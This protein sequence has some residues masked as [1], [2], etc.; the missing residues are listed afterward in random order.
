MDD[1]KQ[2]ALDLIINMTTYNDYLP[3]GAP[4]STILS[5]IAH[6]V[7]F[8]EI[9]EEMKKLT[10]GYD[11]M[12]FQGFANIIDEN[13]RLKSTAQ[14]CL[15]WALQQGILPLPKSITPSRIVENT[16]IFDF[17]IS[18]DDMAAINALPNFGGSGL[19]PDKVDF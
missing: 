5:F 4:T 19:H 18:P 8:D 3:T 9:A 2:K 17:T 15:R 13:K 10:P 1:D 16:N 14:L 7:L 12:T 11:V 6:K